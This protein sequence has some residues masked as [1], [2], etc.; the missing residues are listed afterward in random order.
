MTY[1]ERRTILIF[2]TVVALLI[3]SAFAAEASLRSQTCISALTVD[4]SNT[5]DSYTPT[6]CS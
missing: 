6:E 4:G 3:L 1:R 2:W 5:I